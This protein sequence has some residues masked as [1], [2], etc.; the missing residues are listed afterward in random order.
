M[1]LPNPTP[2]LGS[3]GGQDY[4][5]KMFAAAGAS[6]MNDMMS[7]P[8][9]GAVSGGK[10]SAGSPIYMGKNPA[11]SPYNVGGTT[12]SKTGPYAGG[13]N[14]RPSVSQ[15]RTMSYAEAQNI[16]LSWS[17]K[18]ISNFVSKGIFYGLPHFDS[19]MGMPEIASAWDD[20]LQ[21]SYGFSQGGGKKW[22]PWDVMDSYKGSGTNSEI[23][24]G[25][26]MVDASTHAKIKYVGP[27][28]TTQV[29]KH[30]D[31]SSAEDVQAITTNALTQLLG[32]AP[33]DKEV[34]QYKATINGY[35]KS[36]PQVTTTTQQINAEGVATDSSSTTSGGATDAGR[37]TLI[38]DKTVG[39]QEY[40]KY[41][42][43]TTYYNAL[44]AMI[45]GQ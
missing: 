28:S 2:G 25:D 44:L 6:S 17:K 37:Q 29:N 34:A 43:G 35:E 19:N 4:L 24:D 26:W 38:S 31:L 18:E 42:A 32:R 33:T 10:I 39:S 3:T 12:M 7:N 9:G 30:V 23:R 45:G 36:H 41:Q 13:L 5:N 14:K 8:G 22:T 15:D 1:V 21:A 11:A 40:N 20:L 16:P 27:R